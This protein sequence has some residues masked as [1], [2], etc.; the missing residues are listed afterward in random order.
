MCLSFITERLLWVVPIWPLQET[1]RL[2]QRLEPRAIAHQ[3]LYAMFSECKQIPNEPYG[4][5]I[6]RLT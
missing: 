5:L 4:W 6:F 2:P 1:K 3:T